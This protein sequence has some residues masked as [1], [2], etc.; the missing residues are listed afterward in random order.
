L[1]IKSG[2]MGKKRRFAL[3]NTDI[4]LDIGESPLLPSMIPNNR[5]IPNEVRDLLLLLVYHK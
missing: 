4:Q 3:Y 5:V 1:T 2:G